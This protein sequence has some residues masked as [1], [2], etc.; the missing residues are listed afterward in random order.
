MQWDTLGI[1]K[2]DAVDRM[3]GIDLKTLPLRKRR[4]MRHS[5]I[6]FVC[7]PS[8]R[9][10]SYLQNE[11]VVTEIRTVAVEAF[12][13]VTGTFYV[14]TKVVV[15]RVRPAVKT[16]HSRQFCSVHQLYLLHINCPSL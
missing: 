7:V 11:S 3:T 10:F 14:F 15:T 6:P 16:H 1:G 8:G 12:P 13:G 9:R 4:R 5:V 2:Q